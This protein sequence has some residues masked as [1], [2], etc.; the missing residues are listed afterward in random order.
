[1]QHEGERIEWDQHH[2]TL[3][4][5]HVLDVTATETSVKVLERDHNR[6]LIH[7]LVP[8]VLVCGEAVVYGGQRERER[9]RER[10]NGAVCVY[11][12]VTPQSRDKASIGGRAQTSN[13][14]QNQREQRT[15]ASEQRPT[16]QRN[17]ISSISQHNT[18]MLREPTNHI[19]LLALSAVHG[20]QRKPGLFGETEW[21]GYR[22]VGGAYAA[23]VWVSDQGAK[24]GEN[25]WKELV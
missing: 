10:T 23:C 8:A 15:H 22:C 18:A 16:H 3:Q 13:M 17:N 20:S 2:T 4:N 6:D 7:L 25:S 24:V 11:A 12:D 21:C 9:E 5:A 1:M 19:A 14:E